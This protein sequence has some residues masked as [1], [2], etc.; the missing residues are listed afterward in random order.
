[1]ERI[2]K[3][4]HSAGIYYSGD[5][6]FDVDLPEIEEEDEENETRVSH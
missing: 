1:M 4:F 3:P 5:D 6:R 2:I